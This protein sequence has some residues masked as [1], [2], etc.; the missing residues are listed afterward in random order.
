MLNIEQELLQAERA[1]DAGNGA[2]A[3]TIADR[4]IAEDAGHPAA[5]LVKARAAERTP[6]ASS[7]PEAALRLGREAIA[8]GADPL[9]VYA[10]WLRRANDLLTQAIGQV[11][12]TDELEEVHLTTK[13]TTRTLGDLTQ[14]E[15]ATLRLY[16]RAVREAVALRAAVPPEAIPRAERGPGFAKRYLRYLAAVRDRLAVAEIRLHP[17]EQ[18]ARLAPLPDCARELSDKEM[19]KLHKLAAKVFEK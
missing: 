2:L 17:D 1:L 15:D 5:W 3:V 16:D 12:D 4:V 7:D 8:H 18:A 13:Q 11:S 19:A 6:V 9:L 14:G 10:L